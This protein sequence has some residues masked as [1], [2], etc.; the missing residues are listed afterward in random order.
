MKTFVRRLAAGVAVALVPMAAVTGVAAAGVASAECDPNWSDNPVTNE[1]KPPPPPPAWWT[2]PPEYAPIYAPQSVPP[3]PP[4]P[5]WA[6]SLPLR[7]VWDGG[8][9]RSGSGW[10][11]TAPTAVAVGSP[12]LRDYRHARRLRDAHGGENSRFMTK[13]GVPVPL[14]AANG[15]VIASIEGYESKANAEKG[16]ESVKTNAAGARSTPPRIGQGF[17]PSPAAPSQ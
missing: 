8:H 4:P 14:K 6:Q 15:E 7:P 12:G 1:C 3:P 9:Q 11:L 17:N 13:P 5:P 2:P 16:I 10:N